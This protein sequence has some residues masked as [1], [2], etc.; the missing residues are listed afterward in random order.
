[1]PTHTH[2]VIVYAQPGTDGY[3]EPDTFTHTHEHH[4]PH[5]HA[6][7][8][9]RRARNQGTRTDSPADRH[10]VRSLTEDEFYEEFKPRTNP[11]TG[12]DFWEY[13]DIQALAI[14][15]KYV[16]TAVDGDD[17]ETVIVNGYHVVNRFAYMVTEVEWTPD[18]EC[19]FDEPEEDE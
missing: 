4:G 6:V 14:D 13:A 10:R 5:S 11:N 15:G 9:D 19:V 8:F 3:P 1:M 17:G 18:T 16:W 2:T 12:S 7:G